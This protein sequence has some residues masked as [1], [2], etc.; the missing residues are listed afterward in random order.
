M[1]ERLSSLEI[2]VVVEEIRK[3]VGYRVSRILHEGNNVFLFFSKEGDKKLL[4]IVVGKAIFISKYEPELKEITS[5]CAHLRKWLMGC[6]LKGVSQ[7]D[8][9]RVVK[10]EFLSRS[11]EELYLIVELLPRGNLVLCD[12]NLKILVPMK[13]Q[14]FKDRKIRKGELYELPPSRGVIPKSFEDFLGK[15]RGEDREVVR[16]LASKFPLGIFAEEVLARAGVGKEKKASELKEEELRRIFAVLN[17]TL[18]KVRKMEIRPTVIMKGEGVADFSILDMELYKGFEKKYFETFSEALDFYFHSLEEEIARKVV[19]AE[20]ERVKLILER[21]EETKRD[22]LK[23]AE[24]FREIGK[25]ILENI[26]IIKELMENLRALKEKYSL[27]EINEKIKASRERVYELQFV[28]KV[29]RD[30]V[31]LRVNGFSFKVKFDE[32][33]G[34][35]ANRFFEGAKRFEEKLKGLEEAMKET[36]KKLEELEEKKVELKVKEIKR[37]KREW[38]EKFHWFFSSEDFLVI[39]GRDAIQNEILFKKHLEKDDVVLHTDVPGS[40]LTIVKGGKEAG[41]ATLREAAIFTASFSRA[42]KYN[43]VPKVYWVGAEQISKSPPS[44]QFLPKGS[45]MIRGK[46]NFVKDLEL[47]IAIS[48][49]EVNGD[50]RVIYGPEDSIRKKNKRYVVVVPGEERKEAVAKKIL[51]LLGVNL[52]INEIIRALPSGG[53]KIENEDRVRGN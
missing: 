11:K 47:R 21:Q 39:G 15:V 1:R 30:G 49:E 28:E 4:R 41:E 33:I 26:E 8:L 36:R 46:R 5:F 37:R 43:V 7:Y 34:E 45:F 19:K 2:E 27:E 17:E 44:G 35:V 14:E 48:Y 18:D 38:F 20:V 32:S 40:P 6:K 53:V 3:L 29:E 23:S 52:D 31:I 24:R 10:L 12:R 13:V 42:W 51:K 9:E 50:L 22:L 25:K 16:V